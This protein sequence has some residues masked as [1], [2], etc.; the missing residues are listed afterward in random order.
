MSALIWESPGAQQQSSISRFA[1]MR[2]FTKFFVP[3][4]KCNAVER[5][6]PNGGRGIENVS[7]ER[8]WKRDNQRG[9]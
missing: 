2:I 3:Y 8:C 7:D 9:I 4:P 1:W 5:E 6:I